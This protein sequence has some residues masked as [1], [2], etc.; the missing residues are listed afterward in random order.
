MTA[1]RPTI[2]VHTMVRSNITADK[3]PD[4]P[5]IPRPY[6]LEVL[7]ICQEP[8]SVLAI[9]AHLA[10]LPG[11][12]RMGLTAWTEHVQQLLTD[13]CASP[14]AYVQIQEPDLAECGN[15][16]SDLGAC[17]PQLY[18]ALLSYLQQGPDQPVP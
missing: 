4:A 17:D 6:H 2:N 10:S 13:L 15:P 12:H 1:S 8:A 14:N 7:R 3:L 5:A 18:R 9:A 11:T 16:H